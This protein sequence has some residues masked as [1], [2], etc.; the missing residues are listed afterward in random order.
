MGMLMKSLKFDQ[1][2]ARHMNIRSA[3]TKTCE[4]LFQSLQYLHWLDTTKLHEH[5]GFLWIKGKAGT[6]KSTLMKYALANA[7]DM[8]RDRVI[9]SFFFNARGVDL[10]KSTIGM[11]RSLLLQLLEQLPTLQHIFESL[12]LSHSSIHENYQWSTESLKTLLEQAILHLGDTSVMFFIDA[13]DECEEDQIRDMISFFEQVGEQST[14]RGIR[15]QVC[16]SSRHYP[17]ITIHNNLELVLEKQEGHQHDITSY[18]NSKLK[19]GSGGESVQVRRNLL[20]KASGVFLWVY[21]VVEILNKEYDSG[22]IHMLLQK[23]EELPRDLHELFCDI[24]TRNS[25]NRDELILCIQWILFAERPLEPEEL[26]SAI[27]TGTEFGNL[28][29][30]DSDNITIRTVRRFILDSSKGL[31]EITKSRF[32]TV[33]FIHESVRDF[34]LKENGL[35][36]IWPGMETHWEGR[37]HEQ[38]KE[39]CI[40][41]MSI[42]VFALLELPNS[43]PKAESRQY[44]M[45]HKS[46]TRAFPFLKYAVSAVLYHADAAAGYGIPQGQLIQSFPLVQ[47]IKLHNCMQ[48]LSGERYTQDASLLYILAESKRSNLLK[49][50]PSIISYL[51][52]ENGYV[53]TPQFTFCSRGDGECI[54]AFVVADVVYYYQKCKLNQLFAN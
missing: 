52:A 41:Y 2:D 48:R 5:S 34:L 27:R 40:R 42:D 25:D 11:Y 13:L 19:I 36:R 35:K 45:Y 17:H 37:S 20:A 32:R 50:H 39:I 24:L 53:R 26:Y 18:V 23:L 4:W 22:R 12:H 10:E 54:L 49:T 38:L 21:L 1:I 9:I 47:W 15:F 30:W 33:Q 51:Q 16:F 44:E 7:R 28:S 14:P 8:M 31:A 29:A 43:P 3:H 46:A 6:G